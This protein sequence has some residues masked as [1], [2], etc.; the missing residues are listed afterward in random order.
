MHRAHDY[1]HL[2]ARWK[3]V[4]RMAGI[5]LRLFAT[6]GKFPVYVLRSPA[7]QSTG[8]IY[9]SAGI[10]GDEPGA[11]EAL[12]TWAEQNA[13]RLS[14]LPLL[15][16]P[17]LNPWGLQNNSRTDENGVDL[18]RAFQRDDHPLIDGVK[19]MIGEM[20]FEIAMNLH[21]DFDGEG[22]YLYEVRRERPFWGE[23]LIEAARP[24]IAIEPRTRVDGFK[25]TAGII[26]RRVELQRFASIGFPEAIYLHR[27]H[28]RHSITVESP[29]EFAIEQRVRAQVAILEEAVRLTLR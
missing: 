12:V 29:S 5:R 27:G 9:L 4:G 19:Q 13:A 26:R 6:A 7:I 18:N 15:I 11:T 16:F 14:T 25:A 1:R 23:T 20:K 28:A 24:F 17:C 10:H 2:V 21:E 22:L 8:G 3:A